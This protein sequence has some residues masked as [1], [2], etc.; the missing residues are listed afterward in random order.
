MNKFDLCD[1]TDDEE[2]ESCMKELVDLLE[3]EET[4]EELPRL[5]EAFDPYGEGK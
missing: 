2:Y 5:W 3:I 1:Y 4:E